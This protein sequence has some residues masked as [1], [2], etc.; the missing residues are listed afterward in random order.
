MVSE[1]IT[2]LP[3]LLKPF[4][5]MGLEWFYRLI[6]NQLGHIPVK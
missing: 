5:A 4:Q 1:F 2:L 6:Q 3:R